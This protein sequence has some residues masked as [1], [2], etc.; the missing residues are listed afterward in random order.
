[1]ENEFKTVEH[2]KNKIFDVILGYESH[3]ALPAMTMVMASVIVQ[4]TPP[5]KDELALKTADETL[6]ESV[7]YARNYLK[8][9]S[10][11]QTSH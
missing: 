11:I 3:L 8:A 9:K 6:R 5:K 2:L 7:Q 1:M 10:I 4:S